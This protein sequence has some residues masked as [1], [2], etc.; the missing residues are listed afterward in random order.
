M[1]SS[2]REKNGEISIM[3]S[4]IGGWLAPLNL[5]GRVH[6][7]KKVILEQRLEVG[8]E[9]G[10]AYI[11]RKNIPA[12]ENNQYKYTKEEACLAYLRPV[13]LRVNQEASEPGA[14]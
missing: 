12:G 8:G 14:P 4:A 13:N 5:I 2:T 7:I 6:L 1:P 9:V 10:M 11:G 3:G